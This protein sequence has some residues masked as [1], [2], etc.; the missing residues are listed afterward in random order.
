MRYVRMDTYDIASDESDED[1][2]FSGEEEEDSEVDIDESESEADRDPPG[3]EGE[4][5]FSS[6]DE[7]TEKKKEGVPEPTRGTPHA[8]FTNVSVIQPRRKKE[9]RL[10]DMLYAVQAW[11]T[12]VSKETMKRLPIFV[13]SSTVILIVTIL[14]HAWRHFLK[15]SSSILRY[16]SQFSEDGRPPQ[17][18]DCGNYLFRDVSQLF[19]TEVCRESCLGDRPE[20][21]SRLPFLRTFLRNFMK[22]APMRWHAHIMAKGQTG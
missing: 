7:R 17:N 9:T 20:P 11:S 14:R 8:F 21:T 1:Y 16:L 13:S 15:V 18:L 4:V 3:K 12:P 22:R 2:K 19:T 6:K 10:E 5:E